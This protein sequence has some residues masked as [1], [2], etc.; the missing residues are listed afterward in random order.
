MIITMTSALYPTARARSLNTSTLK[1]LVSA[2]LTFNS[3]VLHVPS[4]SASCQNGCNKGFLAPAKVQR[5]RVNVRH[6][7]I[8]LGSGPL[9][10]FRRKRTLLGCCRVPTDPTAQSEQSTVFGKERELLC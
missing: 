9:Y 2:T 3:S 10:V 8:N 5:G 1:T 6:L 7:S 4:A